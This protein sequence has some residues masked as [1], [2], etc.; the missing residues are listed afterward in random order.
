MLAAQLLGHRERAAVAY[1]LGE[2]V[3]H[4]QLEHRAEHLRDSPVHNTVLAAV[5]A[6]CTVV[7]WGHTGSERPG[8]PQIHAESPLVGPLRLTYGLVWDQALWAAYGPHI[9]QRVKEHHKTSLGAD[10]GEG[11]RDRQTDYLD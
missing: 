6:S 11:Q 9:W 8:R 10:R 4:R 2:A 7:R 5:E 1:I 3:P